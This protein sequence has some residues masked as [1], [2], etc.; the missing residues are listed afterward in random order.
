MSEFDGNSLSKRLQD[1][2]RA[3]Q[4]RL[5][6]AT[7][8]PKMDDPVVVARKAAERASALARQVEMAERKEAKAAAA[9]ERA[10]REAAEKAEQVERAER[11]ARMEAMAQAEQVERAKIAARAADEQKAALAADQKAARDARYA[12][13]KLRQR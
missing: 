8:A 3:K 5:Q 6:R 11:N 13:R 2:K 10:A 7:Q 9:R 12:A 4:A 1:S